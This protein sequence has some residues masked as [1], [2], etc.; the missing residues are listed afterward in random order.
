MHGD[1]EQR[2]KPQREKIPAN[3]IKGEREKKMWNFIVIVTI[4]DTYEYSYVK[5]N[6]NEQHL[7]K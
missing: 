5:W 7:I 6:G 1:N 2:K 4:Y 3:N